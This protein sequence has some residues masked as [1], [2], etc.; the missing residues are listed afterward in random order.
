MKLQVYF[1]TFFANFS[2]EVHIFF[3]SFT[4]LLG[5]ASS[6]RWKVLRDLRLWVIIFAISTHK[7]VVHQKHQQ[8][9]EHHIRWCHY[10]TPTW[11]NKDILRPPTPTHITLSNPRARFRAATCYTRFFIIYC[12][13]QRT[14]EVRCP[15]DDWRS[16]SKQKKKKNPKTRQRRKTKKNCIRRWRRAVENS[17]SKVVPERG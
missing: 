8:S 4:L 14:I 1:Y 11:C 17:R 9:L 6:A 10:Q 15:D 3:W 12:F 16:M 5:N 7:I 13:E 2:C